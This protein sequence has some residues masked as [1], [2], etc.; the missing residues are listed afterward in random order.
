MNL[1]VISILRMALAA[2]L[3]PLATLAMPIRPA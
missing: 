1:T 3:L 2:A